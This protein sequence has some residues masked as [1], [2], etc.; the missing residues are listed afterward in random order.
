[1]DKKDKIIIL[2]I[3]LVAIIGCVCSYFLFFAD[4]NNEPI[5]VGETYEIY[6]NPPQSMTSFLK[7]KGSFDMDYDQ[8]TLNW[9]KG[10]GDSKV[11][12]MTESEFII[13]NRSDA[14]KLDIMSSADYSNDLAWKNTVNLLEIKCD[15]LEIH[16]LGSGLKDCVLVDNVGIQNKRTDEYVSI[17]DLEYDKENNKLIVNPSEL[18]K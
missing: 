7:D 16:S 13:M 10:L 4:N 18:I 15:V 2:L 17:I 9:L 12:F 6:N 14:N 5:S 8:G 11:V 1:M 3:V